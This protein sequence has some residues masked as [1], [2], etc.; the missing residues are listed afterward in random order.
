MKPQ[1]RNQSP[2]ISNEGNNSIN[3]RQHALKGRVISMIHFKH[4]GCTLKWREKLLGSRLE[5]RERQP[6]WSENHCFLEGLPQT[7]TIYPHCGRCVLRD[8]HS[9]GETGSERNGKTLFFY[10]QPKEQEQS[11]AHTTLSRA[12][13]APGT[14][15]HQH[16]LSNHPSQR[17]PKSLFNL[18]C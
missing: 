10:N 15:K 16:W 4:P 2:E 18:V 8:H 12:A 13:P 5:D 9:L 6:V 14:P 7:E 3:N 11:R 1:P 17:L